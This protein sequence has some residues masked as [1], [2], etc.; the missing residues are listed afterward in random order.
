MS[1]VPPSVPR[2]GLESQLIHVLLIRGAMARADLNFAVDVHGEVPMTVYN[3]LESIGWISSTPDEYRLTQSGIHAAERQAVSVDSAF[4]VSLLSHMD[5]FS[6]V[7]H[8]LKVLITEWQCSQLSHWRT[9]QRLY[10]ID[11]DADALPFDSPSQ[12]APS[13]LQMYRWRRHRARMRFEAGDSNYIA[14]PFVDSYHT[15]WFE[16]HASLRALE[17]ERQRP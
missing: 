6:S 9:V 4:L 12:G 8:K 5:K 11:A 2:R 3:R 15:V 1:D 13:Y 16:W 14:S 7:D 10:A 17:A